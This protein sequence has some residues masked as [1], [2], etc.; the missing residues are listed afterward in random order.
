M[1]TKDAALYAR[2]E[3]GELL[4]QEREL[5][6]DE[7]D[8][9]QAKL[10]GQTVFIT[11]LPRG[12]IRRVFNKAVTSKEEEKDLDGEII[13]KHCCDPKFTKEEI[14]HL[15]PSFAS[16]IV[17]TILFESGLDTRKVSKKKAI[18]DAEDEFGKN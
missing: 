17:N 15:R 1:I 14:A 6:I 18:E 8:K 13:E 2:D 3:K 16:A 7:D 12:E 5:I 11:P 10:K 4:P 9:E